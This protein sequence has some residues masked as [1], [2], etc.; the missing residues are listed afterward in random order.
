MSTKMNRITVP[1]P[2]DI[3][4]EIEMLKQERFYDKP[5]SELYR[6]ALRCGIDALKD[7]QQDE[8]DGDGN[9]VN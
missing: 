2:P 5:Y 4:S 6:Q 9:D 7:K 8:N 3:K 1:I